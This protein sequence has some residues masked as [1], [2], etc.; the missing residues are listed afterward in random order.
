MNRR[1][2]ERAI[3]TGCEALLVTTDT[4]MFPKRE[5]DRRNGFSL[6]L[7]KSPTNIA[8]VLARPRWVWDVLIRQGLPSM[9]ML[10]DQVPEVTDNLSATRYFVRERRASVTLDDLKDLRRLWPR[11]LLVKGVMRGD[12][13]AAALAAGADGIVM[14]NHGGRNLE[15]AAAPFEMLP[16]VV[17][18]IG[19]RMHILLDSGF[20]RGTD[21]VKALALGAEGVLFGRPSAYAV[22]A[23]GEAGVGHL[24]SLLADEIDRTMGFLGC[25]A[26]DQLERD[27]LLFDRP[28]VGHNQPGL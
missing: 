9:A 14:S 21:V 4:H 15:C 18:R 27:H 6:S 8:Q 16:E 28:P 1:L 17:D 25:V 13:A 19:G 22:A 23:G 2:V 24:L 26:L 5:R 7:K 10:A 12:E 20:R 3:A 11:K